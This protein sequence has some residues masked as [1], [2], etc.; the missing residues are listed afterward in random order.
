MNGSSLIDDEGA[1]QLMGSSIALSSLPS[2]TSSSAAQ[3]KGNSK[4]VNGRQSRNS[5]V[6]SSASN[7]SLGKVSDGMS[8]AMQVSPAMG[9]KCV[10]S[11]G[12]SFRTINQ[13]T[14]ARD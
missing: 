9:A 11:S 13:S 12:S 5:G 4:P 8:K 14:K 6:N 10:K 1:G 7:K 2:I 3:S